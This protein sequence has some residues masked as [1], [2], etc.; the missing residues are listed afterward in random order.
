MGQYRSF[1]VSVGQCGSVGLD[2]LNKD[3]V[4]HGV[5]SSQGCQIGTMVCQM[6][7]TNV[8]LSEPKCTD[9]THPI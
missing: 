5:V 4:T 2:L 7:S 8:R 9:P 1:R 6:G 3:D